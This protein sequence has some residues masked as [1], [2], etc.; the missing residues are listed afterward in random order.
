MIPFSTVPNGRVPLD[1]IQRARLGE[2]LASEPRPSELGHVRWL[3]LTVGGAAD[4]NM[5]ECGVLCRVL[6]ID[7]EELLVVLEIFLDMG[8]IG[9]EAT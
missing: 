8:E 7:F 3:V 9:G 4:L 6:G 1:Q 2:L 5:L